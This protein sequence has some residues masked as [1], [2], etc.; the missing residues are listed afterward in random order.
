MVR[1]YKLGTLDKDYQSHYI[2]SIYY[3]FAT[4]STVG[5]GDI[6]GTDG[7]EYAF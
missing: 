1:L 4:L 2:A 7:Y 5:Y 3:I 6:V